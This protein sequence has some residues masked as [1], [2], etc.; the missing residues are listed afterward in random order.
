MTGYLKGL[1]VLFSVGFCLKTFSTPLWFT[2]FSRKS[3][4]KDF[5]NEQSN[6]ISY[7]VQLKADVWIKS[8]VLAVRRN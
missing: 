2:Y 8:R 7:Y 1:I 5:I 6:N 4:D 3:W